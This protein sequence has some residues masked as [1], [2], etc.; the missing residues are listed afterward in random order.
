MNLEYCFGVLVL[1][2]EHDFVY[3]CRSDKNFLFVNEQ[4]SS[5]VDK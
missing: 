1:D 4:S 5:L 2:D 3:G